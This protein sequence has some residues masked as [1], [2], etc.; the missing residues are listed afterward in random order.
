MKTPTKSN[1]TQ[2][3][4][5]RQAPQLPVLE[6]VVAPPPNM[7]MLSMEAYRKLIQAAAANQEGR[8]DDDSTSMTREFKYLRDFGKYDPPVF[9]GKTIDPVLVESWV[10]STETIFE[11]MNCPE[12]QK[13]KCA[14]FMLKGEAHFW[15]KTAQQTLRKEDEDE[16]PICWHEMKR[17]FIHKYYPAVYWYNNREAFLHLKQGNM[18]VEEYELEF[19]RLSRFALEYIDTEEKRTYKFIL[20]LRSEIQGKVAAIAA[21]SYARA[22]H[23]ASILDFHLQKASNELEDQ[24]SY[25]NKRKF[26]KH[27]NKSSLQRDR[28]G[29][30]HRGRPTCPTC[31]LRHSGQCRVGTDVCYHCGKSGHRKTDCPHRRQRGLN[32]WTEQLGRLDTE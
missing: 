5:H 29:T 19:T 31:G 24:G 16:E 7:V 26:D 28:I 13:V 3:S 22:L 23:A 18:T 14:S 27:S 6:P 10:E 1:P 2:N 20:G 25:Q 11:H 12:D 30:P 32:V 4:A 17:A 21:T 15:W 8:G 9:E